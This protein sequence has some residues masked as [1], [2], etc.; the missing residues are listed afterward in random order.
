MLLQHGALLTAVLVGVAPD[1]RADPAPEDVISPELR[2][3]LTEQAIRL[4]AEINGGP[5]HGSTAGAAC[6]A[7]CAAGY[8]ALCYTVTRV[9]GAAATVTIGGTAVPCA[10]AVAAACIGGAAVGALCSRGCPP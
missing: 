1:A 9:C 7:N 4:G 5:N 6:A 2:Q 10:T 8:A 3:A